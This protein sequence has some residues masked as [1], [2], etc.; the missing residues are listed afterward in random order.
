MPVSEVLFDRLALWLGGITDEWRGQGF[1]VAGKHC[2]GASPISYG[3]SSGGRARFFRYHNR[4]M[5]VKRRQKSP[6]AFPRETRS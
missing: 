5:L 1:K 2:R 4:K 6:P 3:L